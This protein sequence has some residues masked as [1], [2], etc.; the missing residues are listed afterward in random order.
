[1]F[2][3]KVFPKS[4]R[5]RRV[6]ARLWLKYECPES[7]SVNVGNHNLNLSSAAKLTGKYMNYYV[8]ADMTTTQQE[9]ANCSPANAFKMMDASR[10]ASRTLVSFLLLQMFEIIRKGYGVSYLD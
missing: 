5:K 6:I 2:I 1:M 3:I 4:S 9:W 7:N 10:T 8:R